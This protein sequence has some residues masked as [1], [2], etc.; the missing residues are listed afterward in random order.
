[1]FALQNRLHN[2]AQS[3]HAGEY[4]LCQNNWLLKVTLAAKCNHL[5][6][7]ASISFCDLDFFNTNLG[8]VWVA[9]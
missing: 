1:M 8:Y 3:T 7:A 4:G 2:A 6:N 5:K 9:G